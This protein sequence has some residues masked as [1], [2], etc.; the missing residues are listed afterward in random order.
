MAKKIAAT[1]GNLVKQ[2]FIYTIPLIL[3]TIMQNLFNIADKAVAGQMAGSTAVA[4]IGATGTVTTLILNGAIGLSTG[5]S[6]ILARY[7]G[8][9]NKEKMRQTIDTA[10]SASLILGLI[11]AVVGFFLSPIVLDLIDC[12]GECFDDAVLYLRIYLGAAP[13][14]LCYNYASAILR[15]MGDTKRPLYYIIVAGVV[16]VVLNVILCLLLDNKVLAVAIATV[17]AKL[18]ST[19]LIL[20]NLCHIEG[21]VKLNLFNMHPHF[22]AFVQIFRFGV[23]TSISNLILPL[24]NLQIASGINSYGV[25]AVAGNSAASS[26]HNIAGAF[27]GGFGMAATTFIGQNLG[28]KNKARVIQCFWTLLW[29]NVAISGSVGFLI[30]LSGKFWLGLV[31]GAGEAEAISYG[32]S[33]LLH[34]T[35]ITFVNAVNVVISHSFQAFGYPMFTSISNIFFTLGLRVIWMK[36]VYPL[37]K[38][39]DNIMLCFTVSWTLNMLLYIVFFAFIFTRYVKKDICK[40]I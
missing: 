8:Q 7:V 5:A 27:S 24:A 35:L 23:P 40:R 11:V 3:S 31:L 14:F 22:P 38:T 1:K 17:V 9:K 26:I 4:S 21:N 28:A 16:N 39:F 2:I 36:F 30:C 32:M 25:A 18:V 10:I 12:P 34:V 13:A 15:T 19:T 6:I 29:L 37:K 20:R 33:R